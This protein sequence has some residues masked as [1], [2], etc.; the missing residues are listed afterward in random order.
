MEKTYDLVVIG[1]GSGGLSAVGFGVETHASVALIE[2]NRIGG[3]CTWSGC[4]PSKSLLKAA[5]IAHHMRTAGQYGITAHEPDVDMQAVMGRVHGIIDETYQ[6]ETPEVLR[7]KGVDVYLGEAH[8]VDA[9]T[10]QVGED[11]NPG[12]ECRDCD[13][14]STF[15]ATYCRH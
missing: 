2:K 3:D 10:L 9:H 14:C 6:E 12:T 7:N 15:C 4:V 11:T 1:G 13:R 5:K 8:F